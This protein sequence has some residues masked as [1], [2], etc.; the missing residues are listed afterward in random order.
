MHM[1]MHEGGEREREREHKRER[2]SLK[3]T[4]NIK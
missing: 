1:Q 3:T 2:I 4:S